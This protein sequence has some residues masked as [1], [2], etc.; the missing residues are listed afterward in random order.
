MDKLSAAVGVSKLKNI[1]QYMAARRKVHL[2]YEAFFRDIEGVVV[3]YTTDA[4]YVLNHWLTCIIINE[5][6]S[7]FSKE[8]LRNQLLK[9]HIESRPLWKSIHLQP[10]FKDAPFYCKDI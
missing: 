5:K 1:A 4:N 7:K 9:D 6:L 2:F 3:F 8:D 10:V